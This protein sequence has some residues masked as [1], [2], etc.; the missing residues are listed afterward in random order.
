MKNTTAVFK[1]AKLVKVKG[2]GHC[3]IA[4]PLSYLAKHIRVFSEE[5]IMPE[6]DHVQ[7]E[8][9]GNPYFGN[10]KK[11][12]EGEVV[13]LVKFEDEEDRRVHLALVELVRESW[14]GPRWIWR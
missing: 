9:D 12:E 1:G 10:E 2:Y 3:S 7:Y 8:A 14:F 5:G 6:E 11:D 4:L 13:P